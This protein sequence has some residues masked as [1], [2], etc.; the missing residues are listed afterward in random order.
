MEDHLSLKLKLKSTLPPISQEEIEAFR[1][2]TLTETNGIPL[3]FSTRFRELE[4]KMLKDLEVNLQ[5]LLHTE[6]TYQYLEELKEGD[7]IELHTEVIENKIRRG[8]QFVLLRTCVGSN[9][10][11]KVISE[12]QMVIRHDP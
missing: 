9:G 5:N 8:L 3:T 6:Q 10:I 4:F 1:R 11:K 2:A 12:S 7:P